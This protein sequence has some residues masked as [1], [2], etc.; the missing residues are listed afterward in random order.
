MSVLPITQVV[1][2][3]AMSSSS[4]MIWRNAVPVP[5]PEIGLADEERRGVVGTDHDPRIELQEIEIG[6]RARGA[7]AALQECFDAFDRD[8]G[9]RRDQQS[10]TC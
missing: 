10:R 5:L 8:R 4:D 7:A 1:F 2:S 3:N 9:N 6:I